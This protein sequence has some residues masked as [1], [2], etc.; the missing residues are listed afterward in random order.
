MPG[1]TLAFA[2]P[3]YLGVLKVCRW[4]ISSLSDDVSFL[5]LV[6][7]EPLC[8]VSHSVH[9]CV[10]LSVY[11]CACLIHSHRR[12]IFPAGPVSLFLGA[13]SSQLEATAVTCLANIS[14]LLF[15]HLLTELHFSQNIGELY[16]IIYYYPITTLANSSWS[17]RLQKTPK[18]RSFTNSCSNTNYHMGDRLSK[19]TF[20]ERLGSP[21]TEHTE[22]GNV[23]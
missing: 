2:P 6:P 21:W 4:C 13:L 16:I 1:H 8:T 19:L 12:L 5:S 23:E 20:A 3:C 22:T 14:P 10:C 9:A 7:W 15:S 18:W 11:V 17:R